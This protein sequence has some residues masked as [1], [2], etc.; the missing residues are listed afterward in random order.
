MKDKSMDKESWNTL[1]FILSIYAK[2]KRLRKSR[3]KL[4]NLLVDHGKYWYCHN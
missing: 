4:I 2:S 3:V 1:E